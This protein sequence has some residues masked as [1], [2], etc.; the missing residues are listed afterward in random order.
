MR[1]WFKGDG[2]LN[3]VLW[4]NAGVDTTDCA[5]IAIIYDGRR[6]NKFHRAWRCFGVSAM[7]SRQF[8][9]C[10]ER[11]PYEESE[12]LLKQRLQ[13]WQIFT[14]F[15]AACLSRDL[16][17]VIVRETNKLFGHFCKTSVK[18]TVF[19]VLQAPT[20]SLFT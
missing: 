17:D 20:R 4:V 10:N 5:K 1:Q 12:S 6:R 7:R 15:F 14:L 2:L 8:L 3:R 16:E 19:F 9:C 18:A 13:T 11:A